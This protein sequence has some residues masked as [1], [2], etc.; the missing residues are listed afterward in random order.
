MFSF[1]TVKIKKEF[2]I[3]ILGILS[4][5]FLSCSNPTPKQPCEMELNQGWHIRSSENLKS[6][7]EE[8]SLQ[9][10]DLTEWYPATVPSTVMGVLVENKVY[11]DPFYNK[12]LDIIPTD[13]FNTSWWY[14][15]EFDITEDF[16]RET[17]LLEF[18]GINYRANVW[19]NGSKIGSADSLAG[20]FRMFTLDITKNVLTGKNVLAVEVFPPKKGE[21][22]IGFVDWNPPAPDNNMGIWRPVILHLAGKVTI[23]HPFVWSKIDTVSLSK[24][25][26]SLS[27]T[28]TNHSEQSLSGILSAEFDG[29]TISRNIVLEPESQKTVKFTPE[30]YQELIIHNPRLWWPNNLGS[31]ELYDLDLKFLIEGRVSSQKSV[32]FGVREVNDFINQEGHRGFMVNGK[33]ALIRGGGWVDDLFLN[34]DD[35]NLEAKIKYAVHMNL[36]TLRLEGF[37][38]TSQKLYEL[39]DEYGILL[40]AGWSCHWEWEGYAGKEC[41]EFGG[42]KTQEERNLIARSLQDQILWL[43]N[44]PSI[45]VWAVGSDKLPRP[46]LEKK[47]REIF[48]LYDQTRPYLA[49]TKGLTSEISGETR[50]KMEGPYD[51]VPPIYW[52]EDT[53]YGGAYGFNTE[54]GPGP[55]P[56]PLESLKKMIPPDHLWPI[57]EY[58]NYHCCRGEFDN[59]DLFTEALDQR[60]GKSQ[61]VEEY[62]RKAQAASYETMRAMFEAFAAHKFTSTGVIQWMYNSAW[63]ALNWQLFD[64][65]LRPNG[66]FYATKKACRPVHI[67]Y[68]YNDKG[69]YLNN[70]LFLELDNY[71]AEI[72]IYNDQSQLVKEE[73]KTVY[74]ESNS[75]VRI[76]GLEITERP[77]LIFL[78]LKLLDETGHLVS[79]NVYWLPKKDDVLDYPASTWYVTP[80]KE[81]ADLTKLNYLPEAEIKVTENIELIEDQSTLSAVVENI[82]DKIAFFVELSIIGDQSGN[83]ILPIFWEDNYL[84]LRPGETRTVTAFFYSRDLKGENPVLKVSGWNIIQK[85]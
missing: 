71:T 73:K 53:Q 47:Y 64:Y 62:L 43:R 70:D 30:D 55:Q 74:L 69:I 42:I 51:Y 45:L 14:R 82:S 83:S 16:L 2:R 66:A 22:S 60:Y 13:Q 59:L 48:G 19:L 50:V 3:L 7:G 32:R 1:F 12:N 26:L 40:M 79:D 61:N 25:E 15:L 52:F 65:Y 9:D 10:I 54:T 41:D 21:F 28:L 35:R 77:G 75:S 58:W 31:P 49:A 23:E 33:K 38:G 57:N 20:S 68:N 63:P 81:Y 17:A 29:K 84:I 72:L 27:S 5:L 24:A 6:N 11:K 78:F 37:W 39:C 67:L 76:K 34:D 46:E 80:I 56:P 36:N 8:I 85:E 4:T 18:N 44:H